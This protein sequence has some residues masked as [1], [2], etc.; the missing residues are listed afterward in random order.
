LLVV[1]ESGIVAVDVAADA[2]GG[3]DATLLSKQGLNNDCSL[4]LTDAVPTFSSLSSFDG[5]CAF[6]TPLS[7]LLLP[8]R[9][10]D[11]L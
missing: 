9:P 1:L 8:R 2:L 3:A 7:F 11:S 6:L 4:L 5:T 10:R